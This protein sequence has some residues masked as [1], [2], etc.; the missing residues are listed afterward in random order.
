MKRL[1]GLLIGALFSVLAQAHGPTPQKADVRVTIQAP[2]AV[3][4]DTVKQFEQIADWHPDVKHSTGDG[5]LAS[6][7]IRTLTLEG[8]E[9][10]EELD[11][12]SDGEREYSYRLKT[13]D[14]KALPVSSHSTSLHVLPG[15]SAQSAVVRVKSRFYRADTGNTPPEQLND[16][17][18]VSAMTAFF[19]N[20]L[21]GLK[22]KLENPA[23]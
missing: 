18:A 13:G 23:Q 12:Y 15:E 17:A 9:L 5:K 3:V 19:T 8:G 11:F 4:W 20:G 14:V 6:G 22:Q 10:V 1:S 21:Q 16:A 7:G 2:V